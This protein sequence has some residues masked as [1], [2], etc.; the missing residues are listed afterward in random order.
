MVAAR[1]LVAGHVQGVFF[2][3]SVRN[4]ALRLGLSGYAKNLDDGRVEVLAHGDAAAIE[5][6]ARWLQHGPPGACV[7]RLDRSEAHD[8]LADFAGFQIL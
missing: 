5:E 8:E 6:L 7:D 4:E 2:R 1:F 3:A